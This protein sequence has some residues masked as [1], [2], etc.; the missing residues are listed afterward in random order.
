MCMMEPSSAFCYPKLHVR[1]T[2]HV[3]LLICD[4]LMS[5]AFNY[6]GNCREQSSLESASTTEPTTTCKVVFQDTQRRPAAEMG[7]TSSAD[8][9]LIRSRCAINLRIPCVESK[10][11]SACLQVCLRLIYSRPRWISSD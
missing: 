2:H 1:G 11:D 9:F 7:V 4:V 5:Y 8:R 6:T 10:P 3:S